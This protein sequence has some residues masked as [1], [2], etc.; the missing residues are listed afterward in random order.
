MAV[1]GSALGTSIGINGGICIVALLIF[2]MLR[3]KPVTR[4]FYMPKRYVP[5][6]V[7]PY[8]LHAAQLH[9]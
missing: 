2:C 5:A 8:S 4:K 1:T 7:P 3:V 6:C 9:V